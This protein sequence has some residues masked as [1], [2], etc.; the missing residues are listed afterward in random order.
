VTLESGAQLELTVVEGGVAKDRHLICSART[1]IGRGL[2]DI[3]IAD[4]EASREHCA[5]ELRDGVPILVDLNSAN[6]TLLNGEAVQELAMT[7]GDEIQ[8][9]STLL[10]VRVVPAR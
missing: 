5:I 2:C 4:P 3:R 9:G 1:T 6:G 10:Q 7:D 8:I